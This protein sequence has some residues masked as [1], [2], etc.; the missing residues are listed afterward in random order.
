MKTSALWLVAAG[1]TA[2]SAHADNLTLK[3]DAPAK[4][5]E[6]TFVIGNGTQG[7]AIYGGR[8]SDRISLN[9]ITLW[10]GEPET[11]APASTD[12]RPIIRDIRS[13]IDRQEFAK[14]DSLQKLLQG[15]YCQN[16]QPL[17]TLT[18]TYDNAPADSSYYRTLDL[19]KA[20]P[21]VKSGSRTVN[22][23]ASMPDS[24]MVIHI[25]DPAGINATISLDSQVRSTTTAAGSAITTS[26]YAAYHSMPGYSEDAEKRFRY[27]PKRGIHF[28]TIVDATAQDGKVT[29]DGNSLRVTGAH[30]LTLTVAAATSFN[31]FDRNP[32]TEG[33]DHNKIATSRIA[34]ATQMPWTQLQQRAE[35]AHRRLFDRVTLDLGTTAPEIAALTTDRQLLSYTD[36]TD[37]NPDLEELYFQFG[38]YLLISCSQTPG[39]PANLQGLWNEKLLPPWSSNYT[40]NINLEENYWG[41]ET[42]NLPELHMPLLQFAANVSKNGT[43]AA[44][45]H[46]GVDSGWCLG[47]NTD[48]WAMANPIGM[49]NDSPE[50]ANWAMGSCWVATHIWEHYLFGRDKETLKKYYP[51]LRGAAR[52]ALEWMFERDGELITSPSTSPENRFIAP[53]GT[54]W[55]TSHCS[56]SD[57]ALIRECLIDTRA[58][59]LELD[60]DKELVAE[61]DAALPRLHP[62]KIKADGSLLEW[63]DEYPDRDPQHRH[64]SHLIGLYPG[65]HISVEST[66]ELAAAC[67][68]TLDIKGTETTGW[69]A[70]WR[71]NLLARLADGEKAYRMYRRLLRFV[72]PDKYKGPDRRRGG[73]TYPNLLDAH[74]PFQIDGNFGGSAGVAEMLVQSTPSTITLLPAIPAQWESGSVSGLRTRTGH[75]ISMTWSDSKVQTVTLTSSATTLPS[76]PVTLRANGT[77][78]TVAPSADPVTIS[79]N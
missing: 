58:A 48:I 39:V 34:A 64:Q 19:H 14:A 78:R 53:D 77:E 79:F 18:I 30:D 31:G 26:G 40:T 23:F 66:P 1:L 35:Q 68:R 54:D 41:A 50:W 25:T 47:H 9:D 20:L 61:I 74:T 55:P 4:Y 10:T 73:G 72:T 57:M 52:F 69:S 71:I 70:G 22:Y 56:A 3:Y 12:P 27:D 36:N 15:H 13:A 21:T 44:R 17:G 51:A 46:W 29:A 6:E 5:F 42:T 75:E 37:R 49:G 7:A 63:W 38:R 67:A 59:A 24:V 2:V 33:R 28:T 45:N 43:H 65:H 76:D 16:Y 11:N 32:V 8:T 62:Y 60:T